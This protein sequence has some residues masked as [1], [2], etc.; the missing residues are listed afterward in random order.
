MRG[1]WFELLSA[2][3]I[4]DVVG[5]PVDVQIEH[6]LC[7]FPDRN[8]GNEVPCHFCKGTKFALLKRAS[9]NVRRNPFFQ[10][11]RDSSHSLHS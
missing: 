11:L 2:W 6:R 10:N 8:E 7:I 4:E 3:P 1:F 9:G 5:F